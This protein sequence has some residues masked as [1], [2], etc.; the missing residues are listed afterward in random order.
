MW[1]G[2]LNKKR[3]LMATNVFIILPF[4]GLVVYMTIEIFSNSKLLLNP[5][6]CFSNNEYLIGDFTFTN[7]KIIVTSYKCA[8]GHATLPA[9]QRWFENKMN[10]LRAG[11][12]QI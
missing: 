12:E 11:V 7:S 3:S 4:V 5:Q 9:G 6:N 1:Q 2:V 8:L 10:C